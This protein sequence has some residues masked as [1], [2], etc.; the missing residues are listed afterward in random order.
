MISISNV[1]K[2]YNNG[3]K[4]LNNINFSIA[5][6]EIFA[7]LGENGAGKTTLISAI[8]GIVKI[9]TGNITVCGHDNVKNYR[10]ARSKIGIVPQELTIDSFETVMNVVRF[11]TLLFNQK[12]DDN[13]IEKILTDLNLWDKRNDQIRTLSGGMKRRVMIAK[14]ISHKPEILFLD[15]PSAGVD[16]ELRRSMWEQIN[17]LNK[18]GVTIVLT[19]HYIE[20]AEAIAHRIGVIKKGSMLLIEDKNKLMKQFG[21]KELVI[22]LSKPIIELP[23][24]LNLKYK[25][26]L[27]NNKLIYKYDQTKDNHNIIEFLED[28]GKYSINYNDIDTRQSSL[29]EIFIQLVS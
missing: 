16:V 29:E 10:K 7:L 18:Q 27:N 20:E 19:T 4:A 15:E 25:L 17:Q 2:I 8:C 13:Y 3:F 5:S 24:E 9:S 6:G 14:A 11:S 22:N 21:K 23:S 26:L 28:L 12:P 1:S